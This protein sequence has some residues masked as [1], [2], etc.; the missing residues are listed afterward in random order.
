MGKK[1]PFDSI[2]KLQL[3]IRKTGKNEQMLEWIVLT[4]C[5]LV[6]QG[7]ALLFNDFVCCQS[8]L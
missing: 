6:Q 4:V 2:Y 7:Q 3:L 5:D 1:T 8:S